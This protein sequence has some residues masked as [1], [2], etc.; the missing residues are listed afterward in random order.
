MLHTKPA[1]F[2]IYRDRVGAETAVEHLKRDGFRNNE[3]A[4]LAPHNTRLRDHAHMSPDKAVEG[5]EIGATT[6]AIVGSVLGWLAGAGMLAVPGLGSVIIAGPI[7]TTLVATGALASIGGLWGGLLGLGVPEHE[8][9]HYEGRLRNGDILLS[10][11]CD[12][13]D[14]ILWAKEIMVFTGAE[15]IYSRHTVPASAS[16]S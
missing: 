10:V 2:G 6:G 13:P 4:V 7:V 14:R 8:A 5:L 9:K 11:H 3:I 1:A 15:D 12:E 16:V